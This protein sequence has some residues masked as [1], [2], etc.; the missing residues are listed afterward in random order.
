MVPSKICNEL[1]VGIG[2][3]SAQLV[4]EVDDGENDSDLGPE[5]EQ[6]AKQGD[7]IDAAGNG[8][9]HSVSGLQQRMFAGIGEDGAGEGLHGNMVQR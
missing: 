6:Q 8:Y 5:L 3:G 4:V 9:T 1:S 7:G 2:S